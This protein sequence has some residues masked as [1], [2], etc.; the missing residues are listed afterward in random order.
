MNATKGASDKRWLIWQGLALLLVAAVLLAEFKFM[1]NARLLSDESFNFRQITRFLKGDFSMEPEMN[2]IPG[3]HALIALAMAV[4]GKSGLY[5]ARFLS[6]GISFLSILVFYLLTIKI[7]QQPSLTKTLQYTFFPLFFPFFALVY[8]DILGLLLILL[9]FYLILWKHY[10][11]A[12]L[13]GILSILARSNNISWF[14]YLFVF[15]YYE[16]YGFDLRAPFRKDAFLQFLKRTW[17]YWVGFGLILAFLIVNKGIAI[18]NREVQPL[19]KFQSG[20]LFFLLSLFCLLF[21]PMNLANLP[22]ILKLVRKSWWVLLLL[23]GVY[24]IYMLT[25]EST[26]PYNQALPNYYLRNKLLITVTSGV[27]PKTLFFIPVGFALLSL[28]VTRLRERRFYWLY[29][30]TVLGLVPFWLIEPR[31]SFVP[32]AFFL[33]F[34]EEHSPWVERLTIAMYVV[35]SLAILYFTRYDRFFI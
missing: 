30:F 3:Y 16:N 17:V 29:P 14:A 20:N 12:G 33:L 21:L 22:R 8:M 5:S 34:K 25:F 23:L 2:A 11:L 1:S 26:H 24:L 13:V 4:L 19:F 31:Y 35:L 7:C 9:A 6:L 15:V 10:S 18:S 28:L 27:G 32:L